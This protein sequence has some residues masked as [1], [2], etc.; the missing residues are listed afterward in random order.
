MS[1]KGVLNWVFAFLITACL[2]G[3]G[4][5]SSAPQ[6]ANQPDPVQEEIEKRIQSK[7]PQVIPPGHTMNSGGE[8]V[9]V[10]TKDDSGQ[11]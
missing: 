3:C 9:P 6:S 7:G 5:T 11:P 2:V 4:G 10:E 1:T 8:I